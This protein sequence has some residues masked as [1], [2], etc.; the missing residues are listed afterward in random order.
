L[1]SGGT[2]LFSGFF[3]SN[4][5]DISHA[6]AE[7]GLTYLQHTVNGGWVVARFFKK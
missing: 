7:L 4:L 1:K 5:D 3:E 2:I 6:S